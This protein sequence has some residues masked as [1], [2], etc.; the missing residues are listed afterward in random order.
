MDVVVSADY[1]PVMLLS[2]NRKWK[3]KFLFSTRS[4]EEMEFPAAE[5]LNESIF[6]SLAVRRENEFKRSHC[7]LLFVWSSKVKLIL[8]TL[9]TRFYGDR[10]A[11]RFLCKVVF[12]RAFCHHMFF[13]F[14]GSF[15]FSN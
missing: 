7:V 5:S 3:G 4:E 14:L 8:R 1:A 13:F 9:C 6:L 11:S 2:S 12:P 15:C 10:L